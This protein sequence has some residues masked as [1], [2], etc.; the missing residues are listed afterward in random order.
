MQNLRGLV[1]VVLLGLVSSGCGRQS[2]L[3]GV[4]VDGQGGPLAELRVIARQVQPIEG[5]GELETT[6]G[7]DGTFRLDGLFRKSAYVLKVSSQEWSTEDSLTVESGP[8]GQTKLLPSPMVIRYT[9]SA[10]GVIR[11][12]RTGLEWYMG[13]D[14]ETTWEQASAWVSDLSAAG[15]GW[16]M[17]TQAEL[18]MLYERGADRRRLPASFKTSGNYVWSGEMKNPSSTSGFSFGGT[19]EVWGGGYAN[20]RAFAVRS[21]K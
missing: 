17:P 18:S 19:V 9:V 12:S 7:P 13:P 2:A 6:T 21:R 15:G 1:C 4:V 20:K 8:R 14:T 16:R 10:E 11:D 3:E 5:Y